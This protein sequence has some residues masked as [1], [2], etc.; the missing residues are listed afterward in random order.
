MK[1]FLLGSTLTL[2][3]CVP[4]GLCPS[5][6]TSSLCN[7]TGSEHFFNF[8]LFLFLFLFLFFCL[9]HLRVV[10]GDDTSY[11]SV[12]LAPTPNITSSSGPP[13]Y[14]TPPPFLRSFL[15]VELD[16][17]RCRVQRVS[18]HDGTRLHIGRSGAGGGGQPDHPLDNLIAEWG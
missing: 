8:F 13:C 14:A 7:S 4:S 6:L 10:T 15:L 1:L 9:P 3:C 12:P 11:S 18:A 17:P 2:A 5:V 16:S